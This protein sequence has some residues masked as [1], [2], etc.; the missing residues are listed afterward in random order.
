MVN[1]EELLSMAASWREVFERGRLIPPPGQIVRQAVDSFL[2][3]SQGVQLSLGKLTTAHLLKDAPEVGLDVTYQLRVT[4]FDRNRQYFF[5]RT[6]KSAPQKM[7]NNKMS[8]NEI[9]YFHTSLRLPS[10]VLVLELVA[11][12]TRSDGLQQALGQGFTVLNLFPNKT[13]PHG[14][15]RLYLLHGSPRILL[16]PLLKDTV[17]YSN[18]LKTINGAHL[19]C[20]L[21]GH[22]AF[23]PVMHLLPE[24][25]LVSRDE[26]IPGLAASP[27]GDALLKP[28]LLRMLPFTLHRLTVCL[29][30]SLEAFES[31]LLELI[32]ADCQNTKQSSQ[33]SSLQAIVIQERRLHVGVHNGWCF[34]DTPQVVVLEPLSTV[35]KGQAES[36][37]KKSTQTKDSSTAPS[38]PQTLGLRSNLELRLINHEAIAVIFQLEYVFS[39]PIGRETMLSATSTSR[40]AFLQCL[41]WAMLCPFQEAT[42]WKGE[43]TQLVL[44]G[45]AQPN[46]LGVMVYSTTQIESPAPPSGN[47]QVTSKDEAKH[48][49]KKAKTQDIIKFRLSSS[50]DKMSSSPKMSLRTRLG[51]GSGQGRA[52]SS[53]PQSRNYSQATLPESPQGPKL[54]LSQ[55]A[56]T[57]CYP[58]SSHSSS[59]LPWQQSFP[60]LLRPSLSPTADQPSHVAC[61]AVS[62][63]AHLEMELQPVKDGSPNHEE[64]QELPFTPVH[65][66]VITMGMTALSSSSVSSRSSLAHL[67]STGFPDI[68]DS[69]G[70]V[71]EVLD[72]TEPVPF[73]PQREE[74]DPLQEN[75]LVFQFLAITRIPIAG[76]TPEWPS[77]I[78]FTFQFYRFPP[79]TSQQL[80]LLNSGK[81]QQKTGALFPCVLTS[82]HNDG[83]MNSESPGLQVQFRVDDSFLKPGEK[84]WFLR[85]LA[86]HTMHIDI[87]DSDSLLLIGST[88]VE[89]KYMLRH[90]KMAVQA[91]H[92]VEVLTTDYVG[93]DT[94][95]TGNASNNPIA[96]T[97]V[98]GRLHIR[99]GNIGHQV[100]PSRRRAADCTQCHSHIIIPREVTGGFTGGS[101]STRNIR[102]LNVRNT[103]QAQRLQV[104]MDPLNRGRINTDGT[105]S[106]EKPDSGCRKLQC[107]AAVYQKE[108]KKEASEMPNSM[109]RTK[110]VTLTRQPFVTM[111]HED[112]NKAEGISNMLCYSITTSYQLYASLGSAEYMEF[113]L[114][115]PFNSP[116]T[117]TIQSDDPELSVITNTEEWQYFKQLTKT[118]TLLEKDMFHMEEGAP[119]PKVY[120]SPKESVHIPL[121]YQ[122]FLCDHNMAP[123]GPS[124]LPPSKSSIQ[125]K[126]ILSN[127]VAA[128]TIKVSF[129]AENGDPIA[130]CQVIVEPTPHVVN[131]TFRLYHPEL[132]FLKKN[133]RLPPWH[134]LS[135][136]TAVGGTGAKT[137]IS[138]CCSDPNIICQ[139]VTLVPGEPQ[140]VYLKVPGSP[141]P[142][143]KMFYVMVFI[144]EWMAAPS[145]IWQIYVHFMERVDVSCITGQRSCQSLVLRGRQ[146]AHK[147]K[148]FSSHPQEIEVNPRGVF[149]LPPAALQELQLKVQPWRA[150]SRFLFLNAVDVEQR[151]LVTAWLLCLNIHRPVLSKAFEVCVPVR[152]GRGSSKKITYTNPY[153]G[154]RTFLLHSDH[155]DLLQFKEDKFQI[156][157]GDSYTIGLRFAPSQSPGSVEILVY[158]NNMEEKTEETFCVN[159]NYT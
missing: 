60:S 53:P 117:V 110:R 17:D 98:R 54:S 29:Q 92:E 145:Q 32:N 157:G 133:I 142:N 119:G 116:Q 100:D 93:E 9:L 31:Q 20:V 149:M 153:T 120:L 127:I 51:D 67:Y 109:D 114:K 48:M 106:L 148:C 82:N 16:H 99:T 107:M 112:I 63:I 87:W 147:V 123:Q 24:N 23:A 96:A 6:W 15:R 158:V 137:H 103:A 83:S 11:L 47:P 155:P 131:Q 95:Q 104:H 77:N 101:L 139:T 22:P 8:L 72:P 35:V 41:R 27:T 2:T 33:D 43:E 129:K 132:S 45:G 102:Q 26:N 18:L 3:Q 128:K 52:S 124:F 21:K 134:V 159:V 90:G 80:R 49:S 5:G 140:D 138:V 118:P 151:Q 88:A 122:S 55:L 69:R 44:Q 111:S 91:L 81:V 89:L 71:A 130:I 50:V 76:V 65:A 36:T 25:V 56:A 73:D 34:I 97:I 79:V 46:P 150:G 42:D 74:M 156:G 136:S 105:F 58:T 70:Q 10:T 38:V 125:A 154:S 108:G 40:A 141:C 4:F 115:N 59:E 37:S 146:V 1:T 13:E 78:Y 143:I 19:E 75:L 30:P 62:N 64:L 152:G 135:G 84:R 94:L 85:Y 12:S 68:V 66:P 7:K 86:L 14:D 57:S 61:S 121:K 126:K 28:V 39:A 144:D 113:V